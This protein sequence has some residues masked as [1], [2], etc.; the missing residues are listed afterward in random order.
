MVGGAEVLASQAPARR[1]LETFL[2]LPWCG[3]GV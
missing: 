1:G 2:L 3:V